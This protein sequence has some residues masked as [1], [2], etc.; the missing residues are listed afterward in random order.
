LAFSERPAG[1]RSRRPF[2]VPVRTVAGVEQVI[3]RVD[4]PQNLLEIIDADAPVTTGNEFHEFPFDSN[5]CMAQFNG[6]NYLAEIP[7]KIGRV[8]PKRQ[9]D[10]DCV[11]W[12][13]ND[14]SPISQGG[15]EAARWKASG[16]DA[17]RLPAGSVASVHAADDGGAKPSTGPADQ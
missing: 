4:H 16:I 2:E 15:F 10:A 12:F 6:Y 1:R 9:G 3:L 5:D 14:R 11:A 7:A 17:G 8:D 13:R